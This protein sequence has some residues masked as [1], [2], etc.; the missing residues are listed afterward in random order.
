MSC[1]SYIYIDLFV[2]CLYIL[3]TFGR[4][5]KIKFCTI[6]HI[7][8]PLD[9]CLQKHFYKLASG[10]ILQR[11]KQKITLQHE[12][13]LI[14]FII[15]FYQGLGMGKIWTGFIVRTEEYSFGYAYSFHMYI[16][17]PSANHMLRHNSRKNNI[18]PRFPS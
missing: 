15:F 12:R 4:G 14:L 8:V 11:D 13:C 16:R 17:H 2:R 7:C 9:M 3:F 5:I 10:L 18:Q 6:L 1:W